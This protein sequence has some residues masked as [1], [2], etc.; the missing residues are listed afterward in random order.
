[1]L[2]LLIDENFNH[3]IL[4]GLVLRLPQIDYLVVTQIGMAGFRDVELLRWAAQE[5]RIIITHDR[6]TMIPDAE[7]CV[8]IGEPMAGVIFVP[9][10][11]A[12]GREINDL[13][14]TVECRSQTE[15]RDQIEYLPLS[16]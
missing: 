9:K 3:H 14:I 2:R 16:R 15:M 13:E 7:H 5:N 12:I 4:R 1:M 10:R 11:M 8:R 6:K